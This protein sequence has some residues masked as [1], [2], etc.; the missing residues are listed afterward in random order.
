MRKY[1]HKKAENMQSN[2]SAAKQWNR[3]FACGHFYE[4]CSYETKMAAFYIKTI[5]SLF[6]SASTRQIRFPKA[7]Y[8]QSKL[9]RFEEKFFDTT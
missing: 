7:I 2:S 8:R 9:M 4:I 6:Q 1:S 3:N 5:C